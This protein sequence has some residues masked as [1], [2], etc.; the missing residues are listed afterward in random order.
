MQVQDTTLNLPGLPE[1]QKR[2]QDR[3]SKDQNYQR[4]LE[5]MQLPTARQTLGR[6]DPETLRGAEDEVSKEGSEVSV[7]GSGSEDNAVLEDLEARASL[8]DRLQER[9][10]EGD[11]ALRG[12]G[13]KRLG[14]QPEA[15]A[16]AFETAES[17]RKRRKQQSSRKRKQEEEDPKVDET[18]ERDSLQ[19]T[20]IAEMLEA[21]GLLVGRGE[22]E[23]LT[24]L[25]REGLHSTAGE[26][27][28]SMRDQRP[29]KIQ[30]KKHF[31]YSY[32]K[33]I[34]YVDVDCLCAMSL[35]NCKNVLSNFVNTLADLTLQ[36]VAQCLFSMRPKLGRASNDPF[37]STVYEKVHSEVLRFLTKSP[38]D[39]TDTN[40]KP[41]KFKSIVEEQD[42]ETMNP[43][44]YAIYMAS[45][46]EIPAAGSLCTFNFVS[47][48]D[49]GGVRA[50][51]DFPT[52]RKLIRKCSKFIQAAHPMAKKCLDTET[53]RAYDASPLDFPW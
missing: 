41:R 11:L 46:L 45:K 3:K 31:Y 49:F 6:I 52:I 16:S 26:R 25:K 14:M 23:G 8:E 32:R 48:T 10:S 50:I 37:R 18:L 36:A 38:Y 30:Y 21:P 4:F 19:D 47:T 13:E 33:K 44:E 1:R 53:S 51:L 7:E 29:E 2:D 5:A 27:D 40:K 42:A 39:V 35:S 15:A 20:R 28:R 24:L 34:F 17:A 43:A 12:R 22:L 9:E